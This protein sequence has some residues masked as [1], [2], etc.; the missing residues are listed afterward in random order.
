M[1]L[2]E[3]HKLSLDDEVFGLFGKMLA[4][5]QLIYLLLYLGVLRHIILCQI[6]TVHVHLDQGPQ[7]L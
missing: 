7:R 2:S 5:F 4:M 3:D 6:A 1:R